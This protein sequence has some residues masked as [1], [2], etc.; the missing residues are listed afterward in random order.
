MSIASGDYKH[1]TESDSE[2][3]S[4]CDSAV[5]MR[6]KDVV[7]AQ[8]GIDFDD[9]VD[10]QKDGEDEEDEVEEDEKEEVVVNEDEEEDDDNGK[11]PRTIGLGEM[12]N[13]SA[14]Y[15]DNMV[16]NEPTVLPEQGQERREPTPRPQ[17]LAPA[18]RLPTPEPPLQPQTHD[19]YTLGAREFLGPVTPQ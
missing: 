7:D 9:D 18:L 1:T 15:A 12:V 6:M 10:M 2:Y 13:T 14:D 8:H 17:P 3:D 19:T 4:E 11:E 16:D 5:D